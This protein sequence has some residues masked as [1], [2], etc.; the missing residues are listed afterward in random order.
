MESTKLTEKDR[1]I[2]LTY[3]KFWILYIGSDSLIENELRCGVHVYG[4]VALLIIKYNPCA[5]EN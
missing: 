2:D 4:T 1:N 3:F 5:I